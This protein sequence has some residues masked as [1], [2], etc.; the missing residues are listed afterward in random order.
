M[1]K[2]VVDGLIKR[3]IPGFSL[4][5][6]PEGL[7]IA[8]RNAWVNAR[9]GTLHA[10]F[11]FHMNAAADP[12]ATGVETFYV[13]GNS[14]AMGEARQYQMAFTRV[15]G[16]KGRGVKGDTQT[17]HKRLGA[18]RDIRIFGLLMELGFLTNPGDLRIVRAKGVEAAA[19]GIAEMF[20]S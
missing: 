12:K 13:S 20:A 14:W 19:A 18:I 4:V 8:Q 6:V 5:K 7:S 11:E 2:G 1:A 9:A 16:L 3:G 10:Y 15:T 17:A